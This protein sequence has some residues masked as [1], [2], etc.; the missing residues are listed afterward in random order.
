MEG[1]DGVVNSSGLSRGVRIFGAHDDARMGYAALWEPNE[2][3]TIQGEH[4]PTA[5]V[6][7]SRTS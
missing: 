7:K 1:R 2:V 5:R 3:A 4:G 6:A